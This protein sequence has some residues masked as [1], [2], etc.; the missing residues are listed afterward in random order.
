[1][2]FRSYTSSRDLAGCILEKIALD[3]DP[4]IRD[5]FNQTLEQR[6]GKG[7]VYREGEWPPNHA[8]FLLE[9]TPVDICDAT[10][11]AFQSSSQQKP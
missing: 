10:V 4:K 9:V 3:C 11:I 7:K 2:L 1:V 5:R 8:L 6:Y